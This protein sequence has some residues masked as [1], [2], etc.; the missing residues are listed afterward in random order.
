MG[1]LSNDLQSNVTHESDIHDD[2][3]QEDFIDSYANL[4][5]K[6]L[7]LLKWF[8]NSCKNVS[9]A[10][11]TDDYAYFNLKNLHNLV[12]KDNKTDLLM[13]T[14]ICGNMPISDPYNKHFSPKYM[15][16]RNRYPNYLLGTAYLMSH[17][18]TSK[19]YEAAVETPVFHM[20]DVFITGILAQ[21]IGVRPEDNVGFSYIERLATA[22]FYE[23]T[24]TSHHLSVV[25]MKDMYKRVREKQSKCAPHKKKF[26]QTYSSDQC[27]WTWPK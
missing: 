19:L 25:E 21:S 11:K 27:T 18:I 20:E 23:Q 8:N 7:M 15:Y 2:I 22:C 10:L 24:I 14:L 5:V 1:N 16:G 17:S 3:L 13:G 9:Y 26:L 12:T 4:T 6:S